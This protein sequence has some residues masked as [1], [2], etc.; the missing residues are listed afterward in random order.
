MLHLGHMTFNDDS[1]MSTFC[2]FWTDVHDGNVCANYVN[3]EVT[4]G[5]GWQWTSVF[6]IIKRSELCVFGCR[7]KCQ[8]IKFADRD[9]HAGVPSSGGD[10]VATVVIPHCQV[11]VLSATK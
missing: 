5:G 7:E 8:A 10:H 4:G 1:G 11:D 9:I 3:S 6:I 2:F